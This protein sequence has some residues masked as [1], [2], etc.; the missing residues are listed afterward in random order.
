[1]P[2]SGA[3][4]FA[5]VLLSLAATGQAG[6]AGFVAPPTLEL[7][8]V[9]YQLAAQ[10]PQAL[11]DGRRA[12]TYTMDAGNET[13]PW[14]TALTVFLRPGKASSADA[15]F[16]SVSSAFKGDRAEQQRFAGHVAQHHA[17]WY[18]LTEIRRE[19][20]FAQAVAHKSFHLPACGGVLTYQFSVRY[21]MEWIPNDKQMAQLREAITRDNER[22]L[23]ALERDRW[24]PDCR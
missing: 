11:E 19:K 23:A 1:M 21:P 3:A 5:F 2:A 22:A 10:Q 18:Y 13:G 14:T 7:A 12:W 15:E 9:E 6:A 4:A 24:Q 8:K 16:K 17:Y 20:Q